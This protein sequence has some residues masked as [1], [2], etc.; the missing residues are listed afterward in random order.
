[1]LEP[2]KSHPHHSIHVSMAYYCSLFSSLVSSCSSLNLHESSIAHCPVTPHSVCMS[3]TDSSFSQHCGSKVHYHW[4]QTSA[5]TRGKAASTLAQQ[6]REGCLHTSTAARG[7]HEIK[8]AIGVKVAY[9]TSLA[10]PPITLTSIT[11]RDIYI[12]IW[13]IVNVFVI[14]SSLPMLDNNGSIV[15][16]EG[17]P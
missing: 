17:L 6:L 3:P 14:K 15:G 7:R 12:Y 13:R 16:K 1:M 11:H 5:A 2:N 4:V 9:I 10:C 8:V